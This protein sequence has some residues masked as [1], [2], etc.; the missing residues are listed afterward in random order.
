MRW[1]QA[2]RAWQGA[3]LPAKKVIECP[4]YSRCRPLLGWQSRLFLQRR[5]YTRRYD[6]LTH[7]RRT[8]ECGQKL[9]LSLAVIVVVCCVYWE[10]CVPLLLA[11]TT[12]ALV[13]LSYYVL[14]CVEAVDTTIQAVHFFACFLSAVTLRLDMIRPNR[15]DRMTIALHA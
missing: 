14:L 3:L 12:R 8:C 5:L 1:V 7:V 13:L 2:V 10:H 6:S 15:D 9:A 4:N 11:I